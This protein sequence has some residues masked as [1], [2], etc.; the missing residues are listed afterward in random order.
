MYHFACIILNY[1]FTHE[2]MHIS[3]IAGSYGSSFFFFFSLLRKFYTIFHSGCTNLHSHQQCR[4]VP[5]SPH[6]LQHLLFVD[7]FN[8]S[9]SKWCET[10]PHSSFHFHISN[11]NNWGFSD[12][13]N[14]KEST[15]NA[16]DPSLISGSG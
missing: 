15:C 11:I 16:V 3:V 10:V 7:V 6:P 8:D 5:F 4:S 9:H 2:Y 12:G 1:S 14:G 13:S